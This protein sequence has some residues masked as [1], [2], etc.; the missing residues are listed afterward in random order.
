MEFKLEHLGTPSHFHHDSDLINLFYDLRTWRKLNEYNYDQAIVAVNNILKLESEAA[1]LKTTCVENYEV[2]RDMAKLALNLVHGFVYSIEHPLIVEKLERVLEKLQ[3]ILAGHLHQIN[4]TCQANEA[5]K[6]RDINSKFPG[7][8][9]EL[10]IVNMPTKE[11]HNFIRAHAFEPGNL[12]THFILGKNIKLSIPH[13]DRDEF[14]KLYIDNILVHGHDDPFNAVVEKTYYPQAFRYFLDIDF[15]LVHFS[16]TM[17]DATKLDE[18]LKAIHDFAQKVLVTTFNI[19]TP[20]IVVSRRLAYK[21]HF[22]FPAVVVDK[23]TA[24]KI[25]AAIRNY[26]TLTYPAWLPE[27]KSLWEKAIDDAVYKT[28]GL[29]MI[30]SNKGN[31]STAPPSEEYKALFPGSLHSGYYVVFD[32]QG[33]VVKP[34]VETLKKLSLHHQIGEEALKVSN[35]YYL[36]QSN[37]TADTNVTPQTVYGHG[38]V[39]AETKQLIAQF[40]E[41]ELD[42]INGESMD[43]TIEKVR[44][45]GRDGNVEVTLKPQVCPFAGRLHQ[46][47][48]RDSRSCNWVLITPYST[49]YRCW[50][51]TKQV[52]ELPHVPETIL[53]QLFDIDTEEIRAQRAL[54]DQT[55]E[56]VSEFIF[57]LIK[58]HHAASHA[59][60]KN[61]IWYKYETKLHRW[62][63]RDLL[64]EEIMSANGPVQ[65]RLAKYA[66]R[67]HDHAQQLKQEMNAMTESDET[68]QEADKEKGKAGKQKS[69]AELFK[70]VRRNLQS[71]GYVSSHIMPVLGLKLHN[72]YMRDGKTFQEQLDQNPKLMCFNNGV[73]DFVRREF[74]D[75]RPQD[76]LSMTTNTVYR[77]LD[78]VDPKILN[79]LEEFLK[80][81]FPDPAE[82]HYILQELGS[83]LDGEQTEQKFFFMTGFGANGKSTIVRLLN[84]AM[85]EYAGESSI[86]LFTQPRP[87]ANS[88]VPELMA[89]R[90]KRFV[91]CAE[92]NSKDTLNFGTIKWLTGGDRITG[93]N[94]YEK[95]QSF[96]LQSTFF[97]CCND[98][99]NINASDFGTW[100]RVRTILFSSQFVM[101]REPVRENEFKADENLESKMQLWKDAFCSVL[102]K[103]CMDRRKFPMPPKFKETYENLK[104]DNDIYSRFV[105]ACI[106]NGAP[107]T[108]ELVPVTK[109]WDTFTTWKKRF[110]VKKADNIEDKT[111]YRNMQQILGPMIQFTNDQGQ[112]IKKYGWHC[113]ISYDH[114]ME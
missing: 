86:T 97:C 35:N 8:P 26:M 101:D 111:F 44:R 100:R 36:V 112:P 39:T 34:N 47:T 78:Q 33:N 21:V 87:P 16:S 17:L 40:L 15:D 11:F 19:E 113:T 24:L 85:G 3:E 52:H 18:Y 49:T 9:A 28:T 69:F 95:Q 23:D 32:T 55:D 91:S 106:T 56:V 61:Y 41:D 109:V 92:P 79:S 96:Y 58:N 72:Y 50:R 14:Y 76:L 27:G 2:A 81:I 110:Q 75:G 25:T 48:V 42:N 99:P 6:G 30:W 90:G 67:L 12:L 84:L 64:V 88:P 46:R 114:V 77:P 98:I 80:K 45:L 66:R 104:N 108:T 57:H 89:L 68:E 1:N 53:G 38:D 13:G 37:A 74:R 65:K 105:A 102:V 63:K 70:I 59:G 83:C 62:D 22:N 5:E 4:L 103:Y 10:T 71:F 73:F 51:C 43:P 29:R 20:E 54:V 82:L 7:M 93:R 60:A 107:G 94:L 31:L